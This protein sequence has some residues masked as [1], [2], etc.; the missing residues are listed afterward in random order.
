[1]ISKE[2]IKKV[3]NNI[4]I[5]SFYEKYLVIQKEDSKNYW[6]RCPLGHKDN[7]PSF[8]ILKDSGIYKCFSCQRGGSIFSFYQKVENVNFFQ[9]IIDIA[10]EYNIEIKL[11]NELKEEYKKKNIYYKFNKYILNEYR[12]NLRYNKQA[13]DYL[14]NVRK[15]NIQSIK[16][17]RIGC[18]LND[19]INKKFS[20]YK[21]ILEDLK[22]IT[23]NNNDHFRNNR[24]I[25]PY[26]DEKNNICG[27]NS[28]SIDN[29]VK[30]KYLKSKTSLI[31]DKNTNL[32]GIHLAIK[33]IKERHA[34]I[35]TEGN[36]DVIRCHQLGIKNVIGLSGLSIT[37]EQIK[38]LHKYVKSYYI[39][40]DNDEAGNNL[41]ILEKIYLQITK[42]N[43][44]AKVKIIELPK[45]N[46]N[47]KI[48][49]DEYL[50][51][52]DK[53]EFLKI[54][55]N[56]KLFNEY[57]I[58]KI[59]KDINYKTLEDKKKYV[60]LLKDR[61]LSITN[62]IDRKQY[63]YDLARKLELPELDIESILNN[64]EK[65][66]KNNK[67]NGNKIKIEDKKT[68]SQKY[69][70]SLLFAEFNPYKILKIQEELNVKDS[71]EPIYL[72]FYKYIEK[73]LLKGISKHDIIKDMT[74]N[75]KSETTQNIISD[76]VFKS[77]EFEYYDLEDV[78]LFCEEQIMMIKEE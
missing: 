65:Y 17:F 39:C 38:Y 70:I 59:L 19:D 66:S 35:M 52:N 71:F 34:V 16:D 33:D 61:L 50:L 11:D 43:P 78:K 13:L 76:I 54:A 53:S 68:S 64:N 60:Y 74:T 46:K 8:A 67:L 36:L 40:F 47:S 57:Y 51:N 55:L 18:T 7:T 32:Y 29:N 31:F 58:D 42:V 48:D 56:A 5:K 24:I 9:A 22:L 27:F 72:N 49:L 77:N 23:E 73:E 21:N 37:E 4:D 25:L 14:T 6:A 12:N 2:D 28:R 75:F 26:L 10:K 41:E 45:E 44:Y 20:K 63:I 1:M 62:I 15:I 3:K 30:P 69:L